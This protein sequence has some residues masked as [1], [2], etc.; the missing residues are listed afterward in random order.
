MDVRS[1]FFQNIAAALAGILFLNPI[2]VAAAEATLA[3]A[4]G[5]TGVT[6]AGNGVPVVNIA[7]P[8]GNGLSHNKFTDYNVGQQGLILNNA[9]AKTQSTQLGGIILGNANLKGQAAKLILNEVTGGSP[10]QLRGYTEVAGQQAHV[11]VANPNGIT[12]N[13]CG[14]INTPRATLTTGKPIIEGGRLDR[15]QVDGGAISIEGQGLNASNVDQFDLITRSAK[16]NAE[17]H[18]NKLNIITGVNDVELAELAVSKRAASKAD[19]PQLAIDSSA[20]GGMYAGAIRL[21]GTEQGVGVKLAGDM[22]ASAGD[23]QIDASGKLSLAQTAASGSVRIAAESL[24]ANGPVYAGNNISAQVDGELSNQQ[25]L[26]ARDAIALSADKLVNRGVVE[27]GVNADG[28]RNTSG[29]LSATARE[30]NNH[31]ATLAASRQLQI[32]VTQTLNNQGGTLSAGS[33]GSVDSASLNNHGGRVLSQGALTVT[34]DALDNSGEGLVYGKQSVAV[35]ADTLDNRSGQVSSKGQAEIK[36]TS[37]DNRQGSLV[38]EGSM[39]VEAQ[40]LDNR[41]GLVSGWQGLEV[42]GGTLDNSASGTLSSKNGALAVELQG[43]LNNSGQGALVSKGDLKVQAASLDNSSA[44]VISSQAKIELALDGKLDNQAGLVSSQGDL[45]IEATEVDNRGG[46]IGSDGNLLL[47]GDSLNNSAGELVSEGSFTLELLGL[48]NNANGQ[49]ASSGNLLLSSGNLDNRGGKLFSQGLL[50]LLTGDLDNSAGGNLAANGKL[51][52]KAGG[53]LNNGQGGLI[54]SEQGDVAIAANSFDNRTGTIIGK[55]QLSLAV[56]GALNNQ[57]GTLQSAEDDLLVEAGSLDNRDEGTLSSL[58]GWIRVQLDGLLDNRGGTTQGAQLEISSGDLR[59]DGGHIAATAGG[60]KITAAAIENGT[61]GFYAENGLLE[62]IADSFGNQGSGTSDQQRGKVAAQQID[63]SLSGALNNHYGLIESGSTLRIEA[64]SLSNSQ[65]K[66]RA[67]GSAGESLIDV[68]LLDNRSGLVEVGNAVLRLQLDDLKNTGGEIRHAGSG[69]LALA[70]ARAIAAG[71]TLATSGEL[72]ISAQSW[73]NSGI[74]QAGRLL[75]NVNQFNQTTSGQLLAGESLI[76]TGGSWTNNG[77][78]ASDGDLSLTLSGAYGGSGKLTSLGDLTL[79]AASLNLSSAGRVSGGGLADIDIDGILANSGK[80]TSAKDLKVA[81]ATLN[82]YGTLGSGENLRLSATNLLNDRGLIFSGED[83]SLRVDRFTNWYAD[84]FSLGSLLVAKDVSNNWSTLMDNVS[85]SIESRGDMQLRAA[86]LRNRKEKFE[87]AERLVS[88]DISYE[89]KEHSGDCQGSHYDIMYYVDEVL[90]RTVLSDSPAASIVTGANLLMRGSSFSNSHSR[91]SAAGNISIDVSS[92]SNE[93][94]ASSTVVRSR[95]FRNPVDSESADRFWD[96]VEPGGA[97]S[98]YARYNSRYVY[99]YW[100]YQRMDKGQMQ[101][102]ATVSRG[103]QKTNELNPYYDPSRQQPVPSRILGYSLVSST[104]TVTPTG[105]ASNAV[106]QAGGSLSIKASDSFNNSV[107][108]SNS[109]V[110]LGAN[111]VASTAAS[112]TGKNFVVVLNAQLPPDLQQKQMNP[113][114][115]PGFSIPQGEN[116]LFRLSG[117]GSAQGQTVD[118]A[119]IAPGSGR[120]PGAHR[121]L[122][123][124]NPELTNLKSFMGSDYLLGLL[125]YDLDKVSRRLGDGLFEQRLMREAIVARTGQ[126]FLAGLTSDEAMFKYLM[127][128]AVASKSA[129]KL[130]L[131]V[132]LTAEQVAALTHDIVW[133]EEHEVLG[134]KVLVPVL[135]LAQAEGRLAANGALIQ[136]KEVSLISGTDLSNQGT[137]RA[138]ENLEVK[139]R[140]I[141]NVGGLMEAGKRLDLLAA[142][143]IRNAQ[144]GIIAGRDVSLI[145]ESGDISNER[146]VSRHVASHSG[147]VLTNDYVDSAARIEAGSLLSLSAG[148]DISNVGSSLQSRGDIE[149]DAGRDINLAAATE[150]HQV[151]KGKKYNDE[152]LRQIGGEVVAGNDIYASAGRDITATASKLSAG[153]DLDLL[154]VRDVS[155]V[156]AA[157]EDHFYSKSKKVTKSTDR[158]TQVGSSLEAGRDVSVRAGQDLTLLASKVKGG[159]DVDLDAGRDLN[160]LSAKDEKASFYFKK[161]KGSFGRSKSEQ[162]ESYDSTNVASVVEAGRDLTLNTSKSSDG[163]L[164]IDG[165]RDV[166]IIGSQLK[167]GGDLMVGATRDIAVL[168]GVEEHGSYSKKTKSG[169]LGLSSSGKSKMKTTATQVSSELDAGNDVVIAAG[170]DVRL[171]AS[172]ASAGNDVELRS[173][174]VTETGDI[175]LVAANDTAYSLTESYRKKTGFSLSD[176]ML[177][178][179][180]AKEA[181]REAQSSTSV[182]SQVTAD[183]DAILQAERDI[184][185]IGSGVSAGRN[186][187]LDAGRDVKVAAAKSQNS[188]AVWEHERRT[189]IGLESDRNGFTAFVGN[190]LQADKTRVTDLTASASQLN[191]GADLDVRAGRDINQTGSDLQAGR[192][193]NLSAVRDINL[194]AATE[195]SMREQEE[196]HQRNGLTVNMSHNFG[197]TMDAIKGVGQGENAISQVSSVLKTADAITQFVSGPS[198]AVHL[199]TT[200]QET[201]SAEGVVGNRPSTLTAGRDVN[202]QAGNDING[203]GSQIQAGRDI[204]MTGRDITLDVAHGQQTS[205]SEQTISQSGINGGS[206]FN[207]ARAGVG[208]SHGTQTLEGH[209]GTLLTA[210]LQAGRDVNLDAD[211]NLSLIGTQVLAERDIGLKAGNDLEIRAAQNDSTYDMNRRSGGGEVGLAL[212][213]QDFISVYASVDIG[214]GQLDRDAG[215]Q[216]DAYLYAGNQLRFES[217][218]DT[219]VAGAWVEGQDVTGKVG[220]DLLVSSAPNTGKVSGDE[221]D[222]SLTVSVGIYGSVSA[223]GSVGV[224]RTTGST[225]WVERQTGIVA[226][227]RLDIRTEE[228]TQL[229]GALLASGTDNL[230]LD[231]GTLG[232]RDIKGHDKE[233]SWYANAGGTYTW[234]SDSGSSGNNSMDGNATATAAVVDPSQE[235]NSGENNWNLSGYDYRKEREQTVRATVGQGEIIVRNDAATGQDSTA[236]LNRDVSKSYEVTKDDEENTNLYVS[237]SSLEAVTHPQETVQGWV[238]NAENYGRHSVEAFTNLGALKDQAR[239]AAEQNSLVAALAWAP[240]LLVDAMDS[241]NVP[242]LGIVP[243]PGNHGGL[244]SQL[245][246]LVTGDLQ[247]VRVTGTFKTDENGQLVGRDGKPLQDGDKPILDEDNLQVEQFKSFNQEE[248]KIFTNGIMNSMMEAVANGLMQSGS[249]DGEASFVLAYNPTHGLI[250]DLIESATDKNLQ[251]AVLSGTARNLNGL[252][253]QAIDA[254]PD[255]LHI[256]GHSQGGLLTWVAIKGLDFSQGKSPVVEMNSIQL[257]GAPVDATKFHDDAQAVGFEGEDQHIFQVNRPDETV[258]F[259][260]LPK[261][262]TVSDLPLLLGGNAQY[263]DDP[264][265][266]TLGALFTVTSLF[267]AGSPHSN[268]SCVTCP[269]SAPGSV[270]TQIR[271]IVI[272]PALIDNQGNTRRLE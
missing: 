207:S 241:M 237:S 13:G 75:L 145:A 216:Q 257:S 83:M 162:K 105:T 200:S 116:G 126:R 99:E 90:E 256:Y 97:L 36:V 254:G 47:R 247:P 114:T 134:Q 125:G 180:S 15:L 19:E 163:G 5:N 91:V 158:I 6:Q 242:S 264:I 152:H 271:N 54:S 140:N 23:I 44:G 164:N 187:L 245:P 10:S 133:L 92:F 218:R 34:A 226:R 261:T 217:G 18:A 230:K 93:G 270:E 198:T 179:S 169:F 136:G 101:Y 185:V 85:G 142:D 53:Q 165:G 20:L 244:F 11:V 1:P 203:R 100:E 211:R 118:G 132:S 171:R 167:A 21:V 205:S 16:L 235:N 122:I 199:G 41:G 45:Q 233:H 193:I 220:R 177:S 39:A 117:A 55:G 26:A 94:A 63:F 222:A 30:L 212:G 61:G 7:T 268:Y 130:S 183:R 123:E 238:A 141:T 224:G 265:A 232:F 35:Q 221:L 70:S 228:H 124:T 2:M 186:V 174:L 250:G 147:K 266:R 155:I 251:G 86:T 108:T 181:G 229:D 28:S 9:T 3:A 189:G 249:S 157:N 197:N 104:E 87:L 76:A 201:L 107:L 208:G 153:R 74:L 255:S 33:Q 128:N 81:A 95:M 42:E 78:I 259:G 173:G 58:L 52:I 210:Q 148:R 263:S 89:C 62:V 80:L 98:E 269:T 213:G 172:T 192:D 176:G 71:G 115:L 170:N 64:A 214:K 111:K 106:I 184:N 156:S 59:N 253:K 66:L 57:Q 252:F 84:V 40:S 67:L 129:L 60:A 236:G 225:D 239:S 143:S 77:L 68:G 206:T 22:A 150:L 194:D 14:F 191:A 4:N 8:N 65:G 139:G 260:L 227:D 103:Q 27:A 195:Q 262:D 29:N 50:E 110:V 69:N 168:S 231:T 267:G 121:Y 258:F 248:D 102:K 82:N 202:L 151:T 243:G 272:D 17:L 113:L 146:T 178:V 48:L 144:G 246:V 112:G 149:L 135:Y 12:C 119:E 138:S 182:G 154:A 25:S 166:T 46:E 159:Q 127:D 215:R 43:G 190:D 209:Q 161:S 109:N 223:S 73:T 49:L 31:D 72:N 79:K 175:N 196:T 219:T 188:D 204:N 38:S 160:V 234:G 32:K 120:Q 96:M 56:A 131:G 240:A 51:Q 37:L 88:G 24:E 137:L